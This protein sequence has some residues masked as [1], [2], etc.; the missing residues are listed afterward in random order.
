MRAM[1]NADHFIYRV[2]WSPDDGEYRGLCAEFPSL[3]W[4]DELP[5]KA[6]AGIRK[7]TAEAVADLRYGEA[8]YVSA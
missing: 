5:E 4:L 6:I 7:V 8:N 1:M 3:S 2:T